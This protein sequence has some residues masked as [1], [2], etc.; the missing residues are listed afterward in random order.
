VQHQVPL[1]IIARLCVEPEL[2]VDGD[3]VGKLLVAGRHQLQRFKRLAVPDEEALHLPVAER[4]LRDAEVFRP[5]RRR[6]V[7]HLRQPV[8]FRRTLH[9]GVQHQM[10]AGKLANAGGAGA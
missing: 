3:A 7:E 6:K 5:L 1:I 10:L 8:H 9:V 4:V 2:A